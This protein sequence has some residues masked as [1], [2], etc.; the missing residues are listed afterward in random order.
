MS[1]IRDIL[2][3]NQRITVVGLSP[4]P[5]RPS[6]YVTEYMMSVGYEIYGVNPGQTRILGRPCHASISDLLKETPGPLGI[7]NVF[8][9]SEFIPGLVDE[10]IALAPDVRPK[11]LWLQSG[12][13]HH[14]AEDR[15]REAGI[16][17]VANRCIMVEHRNLAPPRETHSGS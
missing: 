16:A 1:L 2:Q 14:S 6:H 15:A 7:V 13:T 4:N 11:A 8:R 17:V 3:T 5:D 12:I 10:L 9:S